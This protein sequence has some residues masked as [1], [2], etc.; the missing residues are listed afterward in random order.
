MTMKAF[1]LEDM[2]SNPHT[3][4]G[5]LALASV[6]LWPDSFDYDEDTGTLRIDCD[7]LYRAWMNYTNSKNFD[8]AV[9]GFLQLVDAF[10][11]LV[12]WRGRNCG[13]RLVQ[14]M[15]RTVIGR[16]HDACSLLE[17][18]LR[19][20]V[21]INL[22]NRYAEVKLG[23]QPHT[24]HKITPKIFSSMDYV[25][26]ARVSPIY[27]LVVKDK[28]VVEGFERRVAIGCDVY[29]VSILGLAVTFI[30]SYTA[31]RNERYYY[32]LLPLSPHRDLAR[33]VNENIE[34][35]AR[36]TSYLGGQKVNL[37]DVPE[38]LLHL[39][40][41]SVVRSPL[42]A[43]ELTAIKFDGKRADMLLEYVINMD[44]LR[45]L[46]DAL[47]Y[48]RSW[49]RLAWLSAHVARLYLRGE[50]EE[51]RLASRLLEALSLLVAAAMGIG[52]FEHNI[53]QAL[54][55]LSDSSIYNGVSRVREGRDDLEW[56][57]WRRGLIEILE[58]MLKLG[59]VLV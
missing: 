21:N 1:H 9:R 45:R 17:D 55:V 8:N 5:K 19:F 54:R 32:F 35:L 56:A 43:V 24:S 52:G 22:K 12:T 31:R 20:S 48:T 26:A 44:S 18:A 37:I 3:F 41:L 51:R 29:A 46:Y 6:V 27:Q 53:Y 7:K 49:D 34:N 38:P 15:V 42:G 59:R 13:G 33:A 4:F 36:I 57:V 10:P 2:L 25:E 14:D 58:T 11:A 39:M 23:K 47:E 16:Y 40:V 30:G 28:R 50:E